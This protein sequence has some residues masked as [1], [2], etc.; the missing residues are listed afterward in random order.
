[1][2]D[3]A[4]TW[5]GVATAFIIG[6]FSLYKER[7][8]YV[9]GKVWYIAYRVLM[10]LSVLAIILAAAHLITLYTGYTLPGRAPR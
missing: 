1:M 2:T 6:G 7:Q 3:L 10:L 8:P 5:I 4:I 9:P